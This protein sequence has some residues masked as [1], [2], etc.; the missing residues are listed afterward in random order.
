MLVW[1][2]W[3]V[4]CI[5]KITVSPNGSCPSKPRTKPS[6]HFW[7][8]CVSVD[9]VW[10]QSPDGWRTSPP[11]ESSN[12]SA[13]ELQLESMSWYDGDSEDSRTGT[14]TQAHGYLWHPASNIKTHIYPHFYSNY[15]QHLCWCCLQQILIPILW[16]AW[17]INKHR[18][19]L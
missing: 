13:A 10:L 3:W 15:W 14:N 7:W 19:R 18:A 8:A 16:A 2:M 12:G 1:G 6:F 17:L 9:T 4:M 11:W 5:D